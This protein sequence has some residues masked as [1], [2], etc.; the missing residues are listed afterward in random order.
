MKNHW[1]QWDFVVFSHYAF[2]FLLSSLNVYFAYLCSKL[3]W[4]IENNW[5]PYHISPI[6]L[7]C[8]LI[9]VISF[10][11]AGSVMVDLIIMKACDF[12]FLIHYFIFVRGFCNMLRL[13]FR[14]W[15]MI[16]IF[17][18]GSSDSMHRNIIIVEWWL[19]H[20]GSVNQMQFMHIN[21]KYNYS[22]M[23]SIILWF[24]KSDSIHV[25]KY[26]YKQAVAGEIFK[27]AN[28]VNLLSIGQRANHFQGI[29]SMKTWYNF[30]FIIRD[31]HL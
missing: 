28:R 3:Y 2:I 30:T 4:I 12:V 13:R 9:G 1:K 20:F 10:H 22:W 24:G 23:M 21:Y 14:C 26:N 27:Q 7:L 19:L 16:I 5:L 15:I 29:F 6:G 11:C 18:F 25:Q 8:C 17:W 31:C